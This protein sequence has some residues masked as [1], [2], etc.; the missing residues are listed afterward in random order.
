MSRL[1]C[2]YIIYYKIKIDR[3]IKKVIKWLR[4]EYVKIIYGKWF[5]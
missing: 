4:C 3:L 2:K 5:W 1:E